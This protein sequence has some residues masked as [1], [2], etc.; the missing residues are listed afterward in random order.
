MAEKQN[1]VETEVVQIVQDLTR[2]VISHQ[3]T[4]IY[5]Y[6]AKYLEKKLQKR[7]ENCK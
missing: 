1:S 3:P 6:C 4:D 2:E 7:D 5:G